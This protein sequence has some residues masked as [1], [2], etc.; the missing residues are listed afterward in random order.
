MPTQ[1]T[2]QEYYHSYAEPRDGAHD[3]VDPYEVNLD[4]LLAFN[5]VLPELRRALGPH[6]ESKNP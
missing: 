5:P 3:R 6:A 2:E 1:P 4:G